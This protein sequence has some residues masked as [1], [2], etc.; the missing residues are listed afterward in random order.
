MSL[1]DYLCSKAIGAEDPPFYALLFV[2][3]RQADDVNT[4]KIKA[5]WPDEWAEM[6]ARYDA[7]GGCLPSDGVAPEDIAGQRVSITGRIVSISE[8]AGDGAEELQE[9]T[10]CSLRDCS[11]V[12]TECDGDMDKATKVLRKMLLVT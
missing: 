8:G 7:P 11:R 5:A 9:R 1:Y 3:M 10:L 4:R 6:Q 12:L 2:L